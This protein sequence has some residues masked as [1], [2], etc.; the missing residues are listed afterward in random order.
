MIQDLG[1]VI[2]T[3]QGPTPTEFSFVIDEKFTNYLHCGQYVSTEVHS[4]LLIGVITNIVKTNRYF[5]RAESV[6]E[7]ER[8]GGL[9]LNAIFPADRWEFMSADVKPL[10]IYANNRLGRVTNPPSPGSKILSI[11][12]RVLETILGLDPEKGLHLGKLEFHKIPVKLNL[13]K[14]LQKHLAIL[15]MSGAGK[16]YTTSILLEELL[17]RDKKWGRIAIV[18]ID[19]HGEYDSFNISPENGEFQ[20]FSN[21]IDVISSPYVS[22]QTSL[23][24]AGQIAHYI[25]QLTPI[26]VRELNRAIGK[27]RK[28]KK[29]YSLN[30]L[31]IEIEAN[32]QIKAPT[33]EALSSWL[34][35]LNNLHL[36][37]SQENPHLQEKVK[38]GECLVFDLSETL[39]LRKKQIIV[40][41][42]AQRLFW[43][44]KN[45]K[46][47]PFLLIL[48]EAHQFVPEHVKKEN[49]IARNI[50]ETYAR[51]GRKFGAALCLLSQR[52]VKLSTTVL[53]QCGTHLIMRTTNPNDLDHIRQSSEQITRES[54]NMIS[55]L[56]V[57]E[58]LI[59][60]N[61]VNYPLF[62]KIRLRKY[63][64]QTKFL[65]LE[66][67][68][69]NFDV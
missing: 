30:D 54:L 1:T 36:F 69:K 13:T 26:Q 20:D 11:N 51:E 67:V 46:I 25:P 6:R 47:P 15:A 41:Y 40:D 19:V 12:D 33:R 4:G 2:T 53:S 5:S 44:R 52:P 35:N 32:E 21:S 34:N 60:G 42:V 65:K 55:T 9:P 29:N 39:N 50:I 56:P 31:I 28:E 61:A 14:L 68:A 63:G 64:D 57:G 66:E 8:G 16:S 27:M 17:L 43:L 45:N 58:A 23:I 18:L 3:P 22:L 24:S 62:L 48:E 59:T 7:Y 49:A 38:P 37:S 10:G